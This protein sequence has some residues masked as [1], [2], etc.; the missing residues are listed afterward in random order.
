[1]IVIVS[2]RSSRVGEP[3]PLPEVLIAGLVCDRALETSCLPL[4]LSAAADEEED[5]VVIV[6]LVV[7]GR[8]A[9]E[10]VTA[11]G[12]LFDE[13]AVSFRSLL[14]ASLFSFETL[15]FALLLPPPCFSLCGSL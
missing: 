3:T 8:A 6:V 13:P 1:M 11:T 14:P 10:R 5:V 4:P 2:C 9:D 15:L 7:V 12:V